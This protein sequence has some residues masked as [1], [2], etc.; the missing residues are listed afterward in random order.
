MAGLIVNFFLDW[1]RNILCVILGTF[2]ECFY[3]TLYVP[4]LAL[5]LAGLFMDTYQI[6]GSEPRIRVL[7]VIEE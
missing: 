5:H 7:G 2:Q 6:E 3:T 4:Q 1:Q